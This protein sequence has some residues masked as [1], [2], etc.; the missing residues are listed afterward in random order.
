MIVSPA[1]K[2]S[3]S[4]RKLVKVSGFLDLLEIGDEIIADKG[5]QLS[6]L[7]V[8][9]HEAKKGQRDHQKQ[10]ARQTTVCL[11]QERKFS[12]FDVIIT[13]KLFKPTL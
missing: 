4:D 13:V 2:G 12:S 8:V 10:N 1:Y 3:I 5:F 11:L 9:S 7:T 6:R